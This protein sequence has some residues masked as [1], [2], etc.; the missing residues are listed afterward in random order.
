[1]KDIFKGFFAI[2]LLNFI[3][4]SF[5]NFFFSYFRLY[6]DNSIF[7]LMAANNCFGTGSYLPFGSKANEND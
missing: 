4:D 2:N 3:A 6:I 1:M 7:I 5:Y